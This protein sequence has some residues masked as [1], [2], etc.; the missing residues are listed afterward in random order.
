MAETW[1]SPRKIDEEIKE[2]RRNRFETY[3]GMADR[4]EIERAL[5]IQA[6]REEDEAG[7]WVPESKAVGSD[8]SGEA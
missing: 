1:K 7:I 2:Y 4:G 6:L 3:M 5:A 8:R